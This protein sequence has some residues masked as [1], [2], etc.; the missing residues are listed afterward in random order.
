M[1]LLIAALASWHSRHDLFGFSLGHVILVSSTAGRHRW[2]R[3]CHAANHKHVGKNHAICVQGSNVMS[4]CSLGHLHLHK[5][6]PA[7]AQR[8]LSDLAAQE[9]HFRRPHFKFLYNNGWY[10]KKQLCLIVDYLLA[11]FRRSRS[12]KHAHRLVCTRTQTLQLLL[13]SAQFI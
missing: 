4:W 10:S 5:L 1:W 6:Q 7:G 2:R 13:I 11:V 12:E 3:D 8:N 9:A